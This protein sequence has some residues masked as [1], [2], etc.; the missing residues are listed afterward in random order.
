MLDIINFNKHNLSIYSYPAEQ[1]VITWQ[2]FKEGFQAGERCIYIPNSG[3]T[4]KL[5]SEVKNTGERLDDYL[6]IGKLILIDNSVYLKSGFLDTSSIKQIISE[7]E[8][9]ATLEGY[10]GLR[11]SGELPLKDGEL[12]D[13]DL[14]SK[15]ELEIDDYISHC[16]NIRALCH[17]SRNKYNSG[18]LVNLVN[19]HKKIVMYGKIYKNEFYKTN[20]NDSGVNIFDKLIEDENSN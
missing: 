7:A 15:Y 5:I 11:I 19:Y 17:Y 3:S 13:L 18:T 6:N 14:I 2:F 9:K 20:I 8:N 4:E 10:T 1:T 12:M 16:G